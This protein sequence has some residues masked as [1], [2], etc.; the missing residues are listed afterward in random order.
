MII[1]KLD[2]VE[3]GGFILFRLGQSDPQNPPYNTLEMLKT[4]LKNCLFDL[5]NG[6]S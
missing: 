4:V 6:T 5:R 1:G 3:N 2:F